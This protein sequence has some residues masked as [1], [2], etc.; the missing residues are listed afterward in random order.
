MFSKL[1]W[2]VRIF[3]NTNIKEIPA[4]F[5]PFLVLCKFILIGTVL[6]CKSHFRWQYQMQST[7]ERNYIV[8]PKCGPPSPLFC[9]VCITCTYFIQKCFT[10]MKLICWLP[11]FSHYY[12]PWPTA[13]CTV[14]HSAVA[15]DSPALSVCM[16]SRNWIICGLEGQS[17]MRK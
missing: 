12:T 9:H 7:Q 1:G 11:N 3:L 15:W 4:Y 16:P 10:H 2:N 17:F 5:I 13:V 6:H 8:V 14:N